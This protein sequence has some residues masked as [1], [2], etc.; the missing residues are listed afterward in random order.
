MTGCPSLLRTAGSPLVQCPEPFVMTSPPMNGELSCHLTVFQTA[1]F[2]C[3]ADP[4]VNDRATV[5]AVE[6]V[7]AAATTKV[8]AAPAGF[9]AISLPSVLMAV[10]V[11]STSI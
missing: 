7:D 1:L 11:L 10:A 3:L 9:M 6:A 4:L 5:E 8:L 2:G